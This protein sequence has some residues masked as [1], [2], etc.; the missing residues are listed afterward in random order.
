MESAIT[1]DKAK[2]TGLKVLV[3]DDSIIVISTRKVKKP[4]PTV[5]LSCL[6]M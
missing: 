5:P 1:N 4:A 6:A 2:L 3:I